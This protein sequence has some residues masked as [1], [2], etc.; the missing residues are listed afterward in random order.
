MELRWHSIYTRAQLV[1]L[2]NPAALKAFAASRLTRS[3]TDRVNASLIAR[4]CVTQGPPTWSPLALEL[5]ELHALVRRLDALIEMRTMER[6]RLTAVETLVAIRTSIDAHLTDLEQA[7][8]LI[9]G[10]KIATIVSALRAVRCKLVF[11]GNRSMA[12]STAM[13]G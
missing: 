1:S 6:N 11:G 5:Q 7:V 9:P 10:F 3:K 2:I 12:A 4:F 8:T 13:P